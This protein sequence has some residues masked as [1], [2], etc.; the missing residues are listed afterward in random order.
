[1][2]KLVVAILALGIYGCKNSTHLEFLL[3]DQNSLN[4]ISNKEIGITD[5]YV[6]DFEG[7]LDIQELPRFP[8]DQVEG[9][10]IVK[11]HRPTPS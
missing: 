4:L 5:F 11:W 1:M 9:K 7:N 2:T 6:Y 8:Q 10:T 3:P